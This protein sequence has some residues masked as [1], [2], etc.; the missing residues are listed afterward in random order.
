[1]LWEKAEAELFLCRSGLDEALLT[2]G[3]W[4]QALN[5]RTTE[6]FIPHP[7]LPSAQEALSPNAAQG[8]ITATEELNFPLAEV[9]F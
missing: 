3:C 7:S 2:A 4:T 8:G 1:M 5:H 9:S 6:W